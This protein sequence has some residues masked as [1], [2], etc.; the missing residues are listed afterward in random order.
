[1]KKGEKIIGRVHEQKVLE[2]ILKSHQAEFLA[3]Y[4]RRRVGKTF[5][6][7][8]FFQKNKCSF[9]HATG[10]RDG[11][12]KDQL[13]Q[14]SEQI[15]ET[16]YN[17]AV[18]APQKGWLEVFG[19][20]TR[21]MDTMGPLHKIVLFLDEFPWMATKRSKLLQA[22][23]FYWNR[24]W[25]H[26]RRIKLIICGSSASWI[27]EK[28]IANKGG[29][30]NR[31]TKTMRLSPFTLCDT[32]KF[33]DFLGIRFQYRQ[34]LDIYMVLGGVPHYLEKIKKIGK[35]LSA[36]QYINELC[37]K[38]DG[39]LVN[40]FE[41]LFGSLF[42]NAERYIE[43]IRLI[44]KSRYG[45]SQAE[46]IRKMGS[47]GGRSFHKLRQ[48]EEAGFI[49]SFIPHGAQ[50]RGTF[51]KVVDEYTLFYL[52]WIEPKLSSIRQQHS[53]SSFWLTKIQLPSWKS[54]AGLAFEAVCSK[55]V[56][57]IRKALGIT[58]GAEVG[59]WRYVPSAK[60]EESGTQ[61]DLLF[62]RPDDVITLCEIKHSDRPFVID[63]NYAQVLR[64]RI[65]I[66]REQTRTQ[67]EIFLA[68]IA[69]SGMRSSKYSDELISQTVSLEE[70]FKF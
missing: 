35:K 22:L 56:P 17:G 8:Q 4:G 48:L 24:Y 34:I 66:Y 49:S 33:L 29:L 44:A 54:W 7:K 9:F 37:F 5:L 39:D 51:I 45:I 70:L 3:L 57:Q 20:L 26:D 13:K 36:Q 68:L 59:S 61:I 25:N 16:F 31:V 47:D 65:E 21:A 10:L 27:I 30:Y 53:D 11:S 46:L 69:S 63:K 14:F 2:Q 6:I 41:P 62:D 38:K 18:L 15:G 42:Q 12:L 43:M 50:K 52:N 19:E 28:I 67:K 58:T 23:E 55:H 40:E 60:K 32:K 64:K 1:M